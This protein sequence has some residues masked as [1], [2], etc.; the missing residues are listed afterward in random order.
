[1]DLRY[2]ESVF[3]GIKDALPGAKMSSTKGIYQDRG[4]PKLPIF[5]VSFTS[6]E[7]KNEKISLETKLGESINL[8]LNCRENLVL[9]PFPIKLEVRDVQDDRDVGDVAL[10]K[11]GGLEIGLRNPTYMY[12]AVCEG[13]II[14]KYICSL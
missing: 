13:L 14:S 10:I 3:K 5:L 7:I 11:M 1:M 8:K 4:P 12:Q 6:G 9:S 2:G